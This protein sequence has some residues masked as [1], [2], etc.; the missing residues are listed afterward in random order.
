MTLYRV[1]GPDSED[2]ARALTLEE[3]FARMMAWA[4]T[5]Y[6]FARLGEVML[7][8]L[9]ETRSFSDRTL[10]DPERRAD[11]DA[12]RARCA[13]FQSERLDDRDARRELMLQALT[14]N[15]TGYRVRAETGPV[16]VPMGRENLRAG[17][18][19]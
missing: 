5:E 10:L 2:D 3:A 9:V 7:L 12:L 6:V 17:I 13:I 8:Q 11:R 16:L 4:G 15:R 1:I 18:A 14:R 19:N